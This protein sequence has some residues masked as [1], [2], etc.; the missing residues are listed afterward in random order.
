MF[1]FIYIIYRINSIFHSI[2]LHKNKIIAAKQTNGCP[3]IQKG[4]FVHCNIFI[5]RNLLRK[6]TL[7]PKHSKF[8]FS[9]LS[10]TLKS[11]FSILLLTFFL[12]FV[13]FQNPLFTSAWKYA[14]SKHTIKKRNTYY[15]ITFQ[16]QSFI[17]KPILHLLLK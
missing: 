11:F 12:L 3:C 16:F 15:F 13:F 7:H 6:N 8:F 14:F 5:V 1:I 4:T 17:F 10:M 2:Y 9:L